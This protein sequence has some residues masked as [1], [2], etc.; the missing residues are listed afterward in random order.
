MIRTQFMGTTTRSCGPLDGWQSKYRRLRQFQW[1]RWVRRKHG[2]SLR[3]PISIWKP[4]WPF[5]CLSLSIAA[6]DV[7]TEQ[8]RTSTRACRS[9]GYDGCGCWMDYGMLLKNNTASSK[10]WKVETIYSTLDITVPSYS[11][12]CTKTINCHL[13][14]IGHNRGVFS[15]SSKTTNHPCSC[16]AST[17]H[18]RS[19]NAPYMYFESVNMQE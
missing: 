9:G 17:S 10:P 2:L 8:D 15:R 1:I 12:L 14:H 13:A 16:W 4:A 3:C 6:D 11:A 18:S 5:N 19:T 7:M